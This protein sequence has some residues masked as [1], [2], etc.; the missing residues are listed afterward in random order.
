MSQDHHL[1]WGLVLFSQKG[2]LPA[3]PKN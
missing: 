2:F 3:Q 1:N